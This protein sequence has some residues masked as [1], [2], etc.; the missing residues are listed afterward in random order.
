MSVNLSIFELLVIIIKLD[1]G[2]NVFT[3]LHKFSN[4]GCKVGSPKPAKD[5][6]PVKLIVNCLQRVSITYFS[7]YLVL[8]GYI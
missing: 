4:F 1:L 5:I 8:C 6:N 7:I 2:H 3:I